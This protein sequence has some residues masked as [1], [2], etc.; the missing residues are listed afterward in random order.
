MSATAV[1]VVTTVRVRDRLRANRG[2]ILLAVLV[3][4]GATLLALAQ[5]SKQR[6]LL[7]PRASDPSGSLALATLLEG[8]GVRVVRTTTT[9][10][11]AAEV[12]AAGSGST[13]VIAPTA[14]LS[15]RMLETIAGTDTAHL[16][17]LAPDAST[18]DSLAPWASPLSGTS[19]TDEV[20]ANC[21]W[22]IAAR[23]GALPPTGLSYST[24]TPG[25]WLCWEGAVLDLAALDGERPATVVGNAGAFTNAELARSGNAALALGV[26]GRSDTVVWWLP[27]PNDPLQFAQDGGVSISDLVPP[28]VGWALVQLALAVLVGAI[29][30]ATGLLL[31]G[32]DVDAA[33][34][35]TT[36]LALVVLA[37]SVFPWLALGVTGTRADQLFSTADITADPDEIDPERVGLDA[38]IA[39]QILVATSATVGILLVL[40]APL[41]VS[42]GLSGTLLA[43]DACVVVMLR[44]RQYR[45]GTEVLVGLGSGVLGLASVAV[46][47]LWLHPDW[48]PTAA[49]VLAA[50]GAVLLTVTLLP[51]VPSLRR[52]RL[53]D[54]AESACLLGL[55]PL[56]VLATGIYSAI[57]T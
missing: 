26:L 20:P 15:D 14:V 25:A 1:D 12:A 43:V 51:G 41:S 6:G 29:G 49:V 39:H 16:V 27:S 56:L 4:V 48:R 44:T 54:L 37:G 30:L 24:T 17:L 52:G 13:L 11:A 36:T 10:D 28:W 19:A 57:R 55:L 22:D 46:S 53:G 50:T 45:T 18:L 34:L 33:V 5:S 32:V 40:V 21:A 47:L 7:D 35:L 42:L 8:Q 31:H 2:L 9:A 3:L 23:A 38:R